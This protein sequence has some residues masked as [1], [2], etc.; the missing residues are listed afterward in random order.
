MARDVRGFMNEGTAGIVPV[1]REL[2]FIV[3]PR[4]RFSARDCMQQHGGSALGGV[5][6]PYRALN[7]ARA[8]FLLARKSP[9]RVVQLRSKDLSTMPLRWQMEGRE[10]RHVQEIFEILIDE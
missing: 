10:E 6:L 3:A 9:S 5:V 1:S 4:P 7:Y 8:R 2:T